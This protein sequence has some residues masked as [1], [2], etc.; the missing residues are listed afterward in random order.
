MSAKSGSKSAAG[1]AKAKPSGSK[2]KQVD[3]TRLIML[4]DRMNFVWS[5]RSYN[6]VLEKW[7][8][9]LFPGYN[10]EIDFQYIVQLKP[11][12]SSKAVVPQGSRQVA[13]HGGQQERSIIV[14]EGSLI[15]YHM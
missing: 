4:F 1:S 5:C 6:Y 8:V 9:C 12:M 2:S 7:W 13:N 11:G 3:Y 14:P 10:C 15:C